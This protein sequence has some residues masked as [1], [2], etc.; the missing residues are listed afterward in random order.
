MMGL[1][2]ANGI[3]LQKWDQKFAVPL[4]HFLSAD[5]MTRL[6]SEGYIALNEKNLRA[7]RMG[8]QRLNAVLEYLE[9]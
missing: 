2:L 7:T 5:K 1:R 6:Q 8:L 9:S 4:S 3:D